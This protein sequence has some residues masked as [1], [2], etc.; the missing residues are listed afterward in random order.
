[1]LLI[2]ELK[3]VSCSFVYIVFIGLIL[4]SWYDNFYGVT[5]RAVAFTQENESFVNADVSN[6]SI[7]RKPQE[8]DDNYG[9]KRKEVPEKIMC[10]G[11]DVLIVEYLKNSYATYP[12]TYYKEVILSEKEQEKILNIIREITGLTEEQ[13]TNLPDDYFPA[14]NGNLIH[15]TSEL[16]P[17]EDGTL[18]INMDEENNEGDIE[19]DYTKHFVSQ[20]SYERFKELMAEAEQLIGSGSNYSMDMLLEY[21]GQT[22]M[23]Y[24]EAMEEYN[25]TIYDDKVT[26]AFAR[27]FC[28]YFSRSLGF[29][30]VFLVVIIWLKDRQNYM[31][32]LI[33][34]RQMG[35][36]KIVLARF[37]AILI[38]VLLPVVLLSFESLIPL[39]K[40][41]VD[42]GIVIDVFAFLI[43][44]GWWLLPT[45]MIV[46]SLGMFLTI[47]TSTPF[48]IL[49]QFVWWFIDTS[50]TGLSGDTRFYTLM[51]R[52]NTL[53]GS[54]LIHEDL[55]TICLNRSLFVL[56]SFVLIG[57]SIVLYNKK[58]GGRFDYGYSIQ[59]YNRLFKNRLWTDIQK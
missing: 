24:E 21:Y 11:T 7:L 51:I 29:Y 4:F 5:K 38:A 57:I 55:I 34:C 48:A 43:Y 18:T 23:T 15:F 3:K 33:D 2:K 6:D 50:I 39:I 36:T 26:V 14:I 12:F 16:Q 56:V 52:H 27:L 32:E 58:R 47:L 40:Y 41:S 54:E 44:I 42:T 22:E 17:D 13:I 30:P 59:K 46:I 25:K 10:G 19:E 35:T 31:N 49:V 53:N 45:V 1:M 9:V 20:V 28:D 37:A 8:N